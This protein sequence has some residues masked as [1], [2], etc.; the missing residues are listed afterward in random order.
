MKGRYEESFK[1][2]DKSI[3]LNPNHKIACL[4]KAFF[5]FRKFNSELLSSEY[6]ANN[7]NPDQ[8]TE[9]SPKAKRKLDEETRRLE[10]L[11]EKYNDVPEA[12]SLFAQILSEQKNYEKAEQYYKIALEK[13]SMNAALIV[14]RA[15]NYMQWHNEFDT[16]IQMLNEAIQID[17][18][19]EFAYE[20]LASIEIQR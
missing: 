18:T 6:F 19:C 16:S 14:Q 10:P 13:D 3:E 7:Y 8:Q 9:L 5:Q 2:F 4:Q 1:D 12:Y 17:D 11:L 15:L 20:T